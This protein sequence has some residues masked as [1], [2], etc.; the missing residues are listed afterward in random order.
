MDSWALSKLA[1]GPVGPAHTKFIPNH[2][3]VKMSPENPSWDPALAGRWRAATV[4]MTYRNFCKIQPDT[5]EGRGRLPGSNPTAIFRDAPKRPGRPEGQ[6]A[7][8]VPHLDKP[9]HF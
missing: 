5:R 7:G 6:D 4:P 8:H 9:Q 2:A 3:E 1:G